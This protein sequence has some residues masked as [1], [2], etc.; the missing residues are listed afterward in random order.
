MAAVGTDFD[1]RAVRSNQICAHGR[2][3]LDAIG[4]LAKAFTPSRQNAKAALSSLLFSLASK[5]SF[6]DECFGIK[7]Y[8]YASLRV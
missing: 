1:P 4:H 3:V 8:H 6:G 7:Q 2:K 5:D